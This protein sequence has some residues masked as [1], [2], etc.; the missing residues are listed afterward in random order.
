MGR[1]DLRIACLPMFN[2]YGLMDR[3][4]T[5]NGV[6]SRQFHT[7]DELAFALAACGIR[8]DLLGDQLSH[9]EAGLWIDIQATRSQ[10]AVFYKTQADPL[11]SRAPGKE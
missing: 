2:S 1:A 11:A 10:M 3:V 6:S 9:L 7:V 8:P 4:L 5:A